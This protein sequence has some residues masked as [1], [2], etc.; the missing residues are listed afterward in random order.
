MFGDVFGQK[1]SKKRQ[2]GPEPVRGHNLEHDLN[3]TLAEAFSGTKK[4]VSYYHFF[5]C[6]VCTGSGCAKGAKPRECSGCQGAGQVH[7]QQGFFIYSQTCSQC[8]GFGYIITDPCSTCRGQSRVQQYDTLSLSIPA[9]ISDNAE[10]KVTSKGDA[11]TY[12]GASGNLLLRVHV[13]LDKTF[14]RVDDDLVCNVLLTYPQLVFGCQVEVAS[15]DGTKHVIKVPKGCSV[16]ERIVIPEKGFARPR[17]SKCGN[18]VVVTECH[19][20]TNLSS[21]AKQILQ[22]YSQKIGVQTGAKA[23]FVEGLFKKFLG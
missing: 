12:G 10:L 6:E 15:I 19:I 21:E 14:K 18:F 9:G 17:G 3:I 2:A 13:A 8:N 1:K 4:E 11:G 16:G 20:P 7:V 22:E 23:G 5:T